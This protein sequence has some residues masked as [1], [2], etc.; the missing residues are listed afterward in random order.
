[1]VTFIST[2]HRLVV[3]YSNFPMCDVVLESAMSFFC[4]VFSFNFS[5]KSLSYKIS[6][7]EKFAASFSSLFF[8]WR[9]FSSW[10]FIFQYP[11]LFLTF[12][13][14]IGTISF[15]PYF[16]STVFLGITWI[17]LVLSGLSFELFLC[18]KLCALCP[19]FLQV[20]QATLYWIF[21][22]SFFLL[23]LRPLYLFDQT[24]WPHII[25]FLGGVV[26]IP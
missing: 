18:Q 20:V 26:P 8:L 17:V 10:F 21:F 6:S 4:Q 13:F 14:F 12:H 22:Q 15:N 2:A 5:I 23:P 1:M 7:S 11:N 25:I 16:L 9:S 3:F 19:Y 24:T